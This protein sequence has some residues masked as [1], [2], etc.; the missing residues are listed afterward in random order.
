MIN[1][2]PLYSSAELI[3]MKSRTKSREKYRNHR[4]KCKE[5]AKEW[6]RTHKAYVLQYNQ[7][8]N[9]DHN[10]LCREYYARNRGRVVKAVL[11]SF[12]KNREIQRKARAHRRVLGFIP[13]NQIFVGSH[14]HHT[15]QIHVCYVPKELHTS[16]YHNIWTGEGMDEINS[17]VFDWLKKTTQSPSLDRLTNLVNNC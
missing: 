1:A 11:L 6:Y 14:G 2:L 16:I 17:K 7:Q 3:K 13:L 5:Y 4:E 8:H 15:D 12:R 10:R 9:D